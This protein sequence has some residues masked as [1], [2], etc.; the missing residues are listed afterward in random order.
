M[1][2]VFLMH[3]PLETRHLLNF[4]EIANAR[5]IRKAAVHLNLTTSAVSHSLKRLEEDLGSKLFIRDT[6]KIELTYAGQRLLAYAE[7][8]LKNLTKARYLVK[9][10]SNASHQTLRIGASTAACQYIIPLALRELKESLPS[11][12]IQIIPGNTY[13]LIALLEGNKIDVAIYPSGSFSRQKNK[14]C[15]GSDCLQFIVNPMHEWTANSKASIREIESQRIIL[16]G[17][18]DYTF[19]LI[20]EYFRSFGA[21][22]MPFIEIANEEV[23]K[24]L[25][26]LDIGIG[27][28]PNWIVK[29]EISNGSLRS[30]P[31]GRRT[32]RR[33]WVVAHPEKKDLN[34]NETLFI[35]ICKNVAQNLFS[36]L[37]Q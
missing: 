31:L 23:I 1:L 19:N 22:L 2:S 6:R 27:I 33:H 28:L 34:F 32:L 7:D 16:S 18:E 15:I 13:E 4:R 10:W 30:F 21:S 5:S 29:K 14:T 11:M 24:R 25:V 17:T 8:I 3:H 9:E 12:N 26:E 35:G 20:D 37:S 36:G